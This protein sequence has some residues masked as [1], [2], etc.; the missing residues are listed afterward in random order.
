M[1]ET[2]AGARPIS[3][4][5][6]QPLQFPT[7]QSEGKGIAMKHSRK[8]KHYFQYFLYLPTHCV[9]AIVAA[10]SY[11]HFPMRNVLF[12]FG[13]V[14]CRGNSERLLPELFY[15]P[16]DQWWVSFKL[17]FEFIFSSSLLA[18]YTIFSFA[19]H[20]NMYLCVAPASIHYPYTFN[21]V[22]INT[23]NALCI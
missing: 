10:R 23:C 11:F 3:V 8:W 18:V 16:T 15:L 4:L 13:T 20:N 21:C 17:N 7:L 1:L 2:K 12:C 22:K 14:Q 19:I 9:V 5:Q 6:L